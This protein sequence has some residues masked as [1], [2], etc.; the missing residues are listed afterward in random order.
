MADLSRT[1]WYW[2]RGNG[3]VCHELTGT[4]I[5]RTSVPLN[6]V[7]NNSKELIPFEPRHEKTCLQRF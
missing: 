2:Y 4:R 7:I 5:L 3:S 1:L 6:V